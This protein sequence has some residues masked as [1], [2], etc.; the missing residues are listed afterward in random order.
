MPRKIQTRD[1][2]Y[3]SVEELGDAIIILANHWESVNVLGNMVE[4]KTQL[5]GTYR[6]PYSTFIIYPIFYG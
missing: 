6:I 3:Q 5:S 1:I 2:Q 4:R